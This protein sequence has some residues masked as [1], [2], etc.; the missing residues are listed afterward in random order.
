MINISEPTVQACYELIKQSFS[1]NRLIDRIVSVMGVQFAMTNTAELLHAYY[2][3]AFPKIADDIGHKCLEAYNVPVEYGA[4]EA[5]KQNYQT[6]EEMIQLIEDVSIDFQNM[7]SK[8]ILIAQENFDINIYVE[9]I[10]IL[11]DFN[12]MVEQAILLNDKLRIY[13]GVLYDYDAQIKN[14]WIL[15]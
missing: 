10:K 1:Y 6:F 8:A 11:Q 9:L 4:T 3:H 5:G 15:D 14:F 13:N 2:A 12:P 7:L